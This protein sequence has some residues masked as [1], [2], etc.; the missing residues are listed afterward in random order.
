MKK[1]FLAFLTI[2]GGKNSYSQ[3]NISVIGGL[4][5]SSISPVYNQSPFAKSLKE[6]PNTGVQLGFLAYVPFYK[7]SNFG[8]L[9]GVLYSSRGTGNTQVLDTSKT[10]IRILTTKLN[11]NYIDLPLN[12]IYKLPLKGKTKFIISG[13]A[14]ASLFYNGKLKTSSVD[15]YS[16]YEEVNF[17]DLP[18]GKED[19]KYG[20]LH[21][22]GNFMAGFDFGKVSIM[23]VCSKDL[24]SFFSSSENYKNQNIGVL[25]GIAVGKKEEIKQ[26]IVSDQ[27]LDGVPDKDD[28]CP[29]MAGTVITNGCPDRDGDGIADKDDK[30]PDL[31]GVVANSGCPANLDRDSDGI[32]DTEDHCPDIA[33]ISKYHGCPIPDSDADGV[34]DEIDKCPGVA[35]SKK[36]NGCPLIDTA[37]VQKVNIAARKIQFNYASAELTASS[38]IALDDVVTLMK[39]NPELLI[40][41]AGHTSGD[42]HPERNLVLSQERANTVKVYLE[43]KGIA[44]KRIKAVGFGSSKPIADE[45]SE[46]GKSRNRRVELIFSYY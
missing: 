29:L 37:I 41:I 2:V 38:F 4:N 39:N 46:E 30:C 26:A 3:V 23:G 17:E 14:Q 12:I 6:S 19:G 16:H 44:T 32:P 20:L 5:Q 1:L 15:I 11:T 24:S 33:G 10:D 27:D 45:T 43:S 31:K 35:G 36:N 9:S 22:G 8:L 21:F 40:T 13:G 7:G 42:G 25:L 28:L 34:N 18:V